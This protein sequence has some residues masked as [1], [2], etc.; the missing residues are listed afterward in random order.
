MCI[1]KIK[2]NITEETKTKKPMLSKYGPCPI[3]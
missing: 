3:P 2:K 1:H